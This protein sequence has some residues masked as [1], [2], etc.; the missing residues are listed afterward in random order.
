MKSCWF[1]GAR[2][3]VA[4]ILQLMDLFVL[5]SLGE[6][7]SNTVLEAMASGVPVV[8]TAVGG[9]LELVENNV[10]GSLVPVGNEFALCDAL[11]ENLSDAGQ[12]SRPAGR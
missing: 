3:D 6:G 7:I 2:Q 9:N 11:I 1:A 8:A 10:T 4:E 12:E 5:P